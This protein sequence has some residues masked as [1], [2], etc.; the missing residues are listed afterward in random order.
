MVATGVAVA[1]VVQRSAVLGVSRVPDV[2]PARAR[3]QLTVPGMASRHHTIE[4]VDAAGY[5]FDEVFVRACAHE[6]TWPIGGEPLR[7]LAHDRVHELDGLAAAQ[8]TDRIALEPD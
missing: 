1:P 7:G 3:E 8:T 2:Q 6:V 4:H 5:T